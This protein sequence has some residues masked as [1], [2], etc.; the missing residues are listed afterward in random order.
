MALDTG[1]PVVSKTL[2]LITAETPC[3]VGMELRVACINIVLF[4][5]TGSGVSRARIRTSTRISEVALQ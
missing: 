4:A 3:S 5:K 2:P 1:V